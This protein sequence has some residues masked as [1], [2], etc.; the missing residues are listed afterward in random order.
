M[1]L[2]NNQEEFDRASTALSNLRQKQIDAHFSYHREKEKG[3][4]YFLDLKPHILKESAKDF[5][6]H[7]GQ[8]DVVF[9]NQVLFELDQAAKKSKRNNILEEMRDYLKRTGEDDEE[10]L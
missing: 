2:I 1:G 3:R 8:V 5:T 9:L 7:D 4:Q 6:M 10:A